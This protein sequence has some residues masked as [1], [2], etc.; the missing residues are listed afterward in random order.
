MLLILG[1]AGVALAALDVAGRTPTVRRQTEPVWWRTRGPYRAAFLWGFDLGLGFTTIRVASLYWIV[2]LAIVLIGSPAAG[3]ATL[4][5][6]GLA[7]GL[8]LA[9]GLFFLDRP[10][11][12]ARANI[13]ALGL[14]APVKAGLVFFLVCFSALLGVR[15]LAG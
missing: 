15:G 9:F 8:N 12:G 3:A 7:L 13:R 6:Y 10:A 11:C 1:T 14:S 5:V 4:A 2:V